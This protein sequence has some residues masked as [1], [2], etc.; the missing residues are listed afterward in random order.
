[1]RYVTRPRASYDDDRIWPEQVTVH[2][3]D[4]QPVK[5]GLVDQHGHD[6]YRVPERNPIGFR[7][8]G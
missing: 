8:R 4:E 1:M 7:L 3:P 5:T 2:V 6:I